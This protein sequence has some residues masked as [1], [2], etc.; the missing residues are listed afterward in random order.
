ML[1]YRPNP[2]PDWPSRDLHGYIATDLRLNNDLEL[3]RLAL[4][5][6][7]VSLCATE[8]NGLP[9]TPKSEYFL[10]REFECHAGPH[11]KLERDLHAIQQEVEGAADDNSSRSREPL[12]TVTT[13]LHVGSG[14]SGLSFTF[15]SSCEPASP[16]L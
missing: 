5:V 4:S 3:C 9:W 11:P 13:M 10:E 2:V 12:Q 6:S 7:S 8:L 1:L 14:E 16:P 15:E